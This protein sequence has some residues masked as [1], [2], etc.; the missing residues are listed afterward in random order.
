MSIKTNE[1]FL[2]DIMMNDDLYYESCIAELESMLE[3]ELSKSEAEINETFIDE[4][5]TAIEYLHSVQTGE[6]ISSG[7]A[8]VD[9]ESMIKAH[10]RRSKYI[11]MISVSCAAVAVL[12]TVFSLAFADANEQ[13]KLMSHEAQGSFY[14]RTGI[15]K[16]TEEDTTAESEVYT[17]EPVATTEEQTENSDTQVSTENNKVEDKPTLNSEGYYEL[18]SYNDL[19]WFADYVNSGNNSANAVIMDTIKFPETQWTPIGSESKPY[20]GNFN[21][22]NYSISGI[23]FESDSES[24]V[25]MFGC[26][27]NGGIVEN[28][29]LSISY[30]L[31]NEYI[32]GICGKNY[33]TIYA[34]SVSGSIEGGK[35]IGGIAGCN[36][37]DI[38]GCYSSSEVIGVQAVGGVAGINESGKIADSN[39]CN[40]VYAEDDAGGIAGVCKATI[41][42]CDSS[43]I[44]D[45]KKNTGGIVG[46]AEETAVI[47]ECCRDSACDGFRV[48]GDIVGLNKT[49]NIEG[50]KH[51]SILGEGVGYCEYHSTG[52]CLRCDIKREY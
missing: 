32:G 42:N 27:G 20:T 50:C 5:C 4:C 13:S 22:G 52:S 1:N 35:Y 15:N 38:I 43:G 40:F 34:C 2:S 24:V 49:A 19:K 26:V 31:G 29:D 10:H 18:Y 46:V 8:I 28:V 16:T 6:P 7:K 21:G 25:G 9:I 23:F 36:S 44:V 14:E 41:V 51:Q 45:G 48:Y 30:L 11:Y 39:V 3:M 33:G 12:F 17:T 37:G 47:K